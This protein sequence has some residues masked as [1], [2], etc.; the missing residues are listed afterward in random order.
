MH[1]DLS[2]L[3]SGELPEAQERALRARIAADPALAA[4]WRRMQALPTDLAGL[5]RAVPPAVL[6]ASAPSSRWGWGLAALA[7]AALLLVTLPASPA[8]LSLASGVLLTDG[9]AKITVPGGVLTSTG[10]MRVDVEPSAALAREMGQEDPMSKTHLLS[11]AAGALITVAVYEGRAHFEPSGSGAAAADIGP[12][13]RRVVMGRPAPTSRTSAS[14]DAEPAGAPDADASDLQKRVGELELQL[15]MA[16]GQ[17]SAIEGTPQPWPAELPAAYRPEGF[18]ATARSVADA[19]PGTKLASVDCSEYPCLAFFTTDQPG[20]DWGRQVAQTFPDA[21]GE[22]A[23]VWQMASST[24]HGGGA[25]GVTG[26]SVTQPTETDD[27]RAISQRLQTRA[28]PVM[29]ELSAP[30]DEP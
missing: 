26:I 16:R 1:E 29:E 10:K 19:L 14:S 20:E 13:E 28:Q 21:Q 25:R 11:A 4:A 7:A 22:N 24:D 27:A 30:S 12:G 2:R 15:A 9:A 3:L 17:L 6:S 23:S 5:P 18:E 8:E